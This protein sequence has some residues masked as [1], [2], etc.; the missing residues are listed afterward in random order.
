M[1]AC[2]DGTNCVCL[3]ADDESESPEK[4]DEQHTNFSRGKRLKSLLNLLAGKQLDLESMPAQSACWRACTYQPV[5][6]QQSILLLSLLNLLSG[7]LMGTGLSFLT[8]D[9]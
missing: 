5:P 4:D 6:T 8:V 2:I 7:R 3:R 1:T 9:T